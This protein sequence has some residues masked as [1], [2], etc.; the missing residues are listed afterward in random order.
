MSMA[1]MNVLPRGM[2]ICA[3]LYMYAQ[4]YMCTLNMLAHYFVHVGTQ[5]HG[6]DYV[7]PKTSICTHVHVCGVG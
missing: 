3:P 6:Q 1:N 5:L 2:F 4:L 7:V